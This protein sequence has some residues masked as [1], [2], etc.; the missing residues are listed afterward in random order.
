MIVLLLCLILGAL[1][2]QL[3]TAH[4][5]HA[6]VLA[7]LRLHCEHAQ[8]LVAQSD[9]RRGLIASGEGLHL[10][11]QRLKARMDELQGN[12]AAHG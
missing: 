1:I 10:L 7:V 3:W 9:H 8:T 5:Q 4:R 12:D 2:G 11:R 6:E